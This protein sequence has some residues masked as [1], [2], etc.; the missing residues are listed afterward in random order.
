M[1]KSHFISS[2]GEKTVAE[3]EAGLAPSTEHGADLRFH[4]VVRDREDGR[5]IT[6]IDYTAYRPMADRELEAV[7]AAMSAEHPEHRVAVYHRIGFVAAGEASILIRVQTAHSA[8]AFTLCQEY[9]RRI[10][11]TVP[12][13]KEPIWAT[14]AEPV[15]E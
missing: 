9:L 2:L 1:E 14:E 3:F 11:T 12:I 4:G 5:F 8:A 6:G 13:W 7:V 15:R 10:K